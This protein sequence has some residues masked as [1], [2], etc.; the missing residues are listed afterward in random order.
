MRILVSTQCA[1]GESIC[2]VLKYL[3]H[4]VI[5]WNQYEK[6]L[7]DIFHECKPEHVF[8]QEES[9]ELKAC[10]NKYKFN[11]TLIPELIR[12]VGY[13][14]DPFMYQP[15]Q[16]NSALTAYKVSFLDRAYEAANLDQDLDFA[17]GQE[18]RIFCPEFI[19]SEY[20]CGSVNDR[21]K[22]LIAS[23]AYLIKCATE[24][25][26]V[27]FSLCNNNTVYNYRKISKPLDHTVFNIGDYF[28]W[29]NSKKEL[30]RYINDM[31]S[32]NQQSE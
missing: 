31:W 25:S 5:F 2:R 14:S 26:M 19:D 24:Q 3:N 30:E 22:S 8:F 23:N 17:A 15:A 1:M 32:S 9:D 13:L 10:G 28:G 7:F 27:N 29:F 20:Y 4:E 21:Y 6:P 12:D 18:Y 16:K 11:I